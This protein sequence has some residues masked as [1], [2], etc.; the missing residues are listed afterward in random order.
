MIFFLSLSALS[1]LLLPA[2]SVVPV[3]FH[4][5]RYFDFIPSVHSMLCFQQSFSFIFCSV[6]SLSLLHSLPGNI[7]LSTVLCLSMPFSSFLPFFFIPVFH[8]HSCCNILV[9]SWQLRDRGEGWSI[10]IDFFSKFALYEPRAFYFSPW[11]L[12]FYSLG[13]LWANQSQILSAILN[14]QYF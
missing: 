11:R 8:F 13:S 14:C 12:Q 9:K 4:S 7:L 2:S 3:H 6:V 10:F 5:L 1:S